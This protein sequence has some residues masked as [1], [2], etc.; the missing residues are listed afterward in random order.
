MS[1][2]L[3]RGV[4][5]IETD[6]LVDRSSCREYPPYE[7][8][9]PSLDLEIYKDYLP[10]PNSEEL[11]EENDDSDA[12]WNSLAEPEKVEVDTHDQ[13]PTN[14]IERWAETIIAKKLLD[15]GTVSPEERQK[16][17]ELLSN[18]LM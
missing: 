12:F 7:D 10:P 15:G 17:V 1:N 11:D 16:I 4:N 13:N 2:K 9:F 3:R 6:T 5:S 14:D 8:L 18:A